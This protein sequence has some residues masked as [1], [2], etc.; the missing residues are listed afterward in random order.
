MKGFLRILSYIKRYYGYAIGNLLFNILTILF[1]LVSLTMLIPVLGLLF[2]TDIVNT[3]VPPAP[4]FSLSAD[5]VIEAFQ[6]WFI[7]IVL[8]DRKEALIAICI[9]VPIIF[10]LKNLF[11][12][13]ALF[14]LAPIRNGVV[15]DIRKNL[16]RTILGLHLG[17]FSDERRGD[18]LTRMTSDVQE[19]EHNIINTV[20]VL[21]KEPLTIIFF[22]G[23]LFY[24]SPSLTI[25]VLVM[26]VVAGV[27]VGSI[28]KT[29]KR[30]STKGQEKLAELISIIDE[31]LGG[32]RIIKAFTAEK[33]QDT[34]FY[35]HNI[36]YA[37]IMTK[38]LRRTGL[39]S[40]LTEFLAIGIISIVLWYGG[41]LVLE[42]NGPEQIQP[43]VFITFM[44]IF[45]QMIAPAKAF[46]AAFY[47][48]QRGMASADRVFALL[49]TENTIKEAP[50]AKSINQFKESIEFK[51]VSFSYKN[52]DDKRILDDV[53]LTIK[54][55]KMIALVGPSGAGKS[56]MADL[57]P[58]F[59]DIEEGVIL[60]DGV[61]I[62]EYKIKELRMLLGMVSQEAILFND[63]VFNNISFGLENASKEDVI[64]AAKVANAHDFIMKLENGYNTM[65]GE[66][67][68]K[69]SGGQK[70]RITIARAILVDPPILI[71]DEATS[72][73]DTESEK[74]VQEAIYKLMQN[75]T[76]LVIAHRLST[77]QFADE[78]LVIQDG[79][80]TERGNHIGLM[81]KN[82]S[83][84]KLV[85]LQ[86]F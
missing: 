7:P 49:D 1:S 81:A 24:I 86:A 28:G 45:S 11:R 64:A 68:N 18:I 16:Y 12:Y 46:S 72:A 23:S 71:L 57:I 78:I 66:R 26:I 20:E 52:Y 31:S 74:L 76:S 50:N 6:H 34:K 62:R 40:P 2:K 82:G 22:L 33:H 39:S 29:L 37:G 17:Y 43:E 42:G 59:Y 84:R 73:L 85:D 83:Y 56:T 3:K 38:L 58:R 9:L 65:L 8:E 63:S 55:G 32:V 41:S 69:L 54:K 10:F 13:L 44:V 36:A 77:I 79:K 80:I 67:G 27:V 48:I 4:K 14:C 21:F 5:Y 53:N 70:Q 19:I 25:F 51:N 47:N 61:D 75:R 35:H 60:I 30:T 15:K